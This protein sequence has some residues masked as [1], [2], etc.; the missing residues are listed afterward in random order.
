VV[1][2]KV[3]V[4]SKEGEGKTPLAFLFSAFCCGFP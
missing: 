1:A 3:A 4:N 2:V